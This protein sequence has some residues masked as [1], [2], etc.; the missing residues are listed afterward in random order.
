MLHSNII[1][2][3][4]ALNVPTCAV[5]LIK[6]YLTNRSMCMKYKGVTSSFKSC[7]G[8]GPQGGLLTQVFFIL[9]VNK[10]G[11][12][13]PRNQPPAPW[14][15]D[16][17]TFPKPKINPAYLQPPDC[18]TGP[19]QDA[20]R[21]MEE[22]PLC[23]QTSKTHKKSYIDDLTLF[24]KVSLS[25]LI[26]KERKI[27]PLNFHDRFNLTLPENKSILQHQLNDLIKYTENNSMKLNSKKTKL[28]PF[29]NSRTKDF[30]PIIKTQDG[31]QLEVIYQLK[32]VGLMVTSDLT[33]GAHIEYTVERVN[34]VIWQ[35]V[36]FR[37]LGAT[38]EQLLTFYTLKIRSILMFGSVCFHSSL[39]QELTRQLELQQ[40][41]CFLIIL[42]QEYQSYRQARQLTGIPS[43]EE[44]REAACLRW[45]RR[46]QASTHHSHLFPRTTT[47]ITRQS[48][49]F[50]EY[51]CRS[52]RYFNSTVPYMARLLN[53]HG[54]SA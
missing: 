25:E 29:I 48:R 2:S 21:E 5:R 9:Q 46:A 23:H 35:L 27:G 40:R 19:R 41:R 52:A 1:C 30:S 14:V 12:P 37:Q 8:G 31:T 36:R 51:S 28:I 33:W 34:K 45:A 24:E 53:T 6:S 10:A 7:P 44:S 16:Q 3:L 22:Q 17:S 38:R 18:I 4:L 20:T 49:E 15:E 54:A 47:T 39:T 11:Q 42:G 43:L 32:L 26:E 50:Q 13:C